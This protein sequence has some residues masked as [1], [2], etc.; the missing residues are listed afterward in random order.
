M[1]L[2]ENSTVLISIPALWML[3]VMT[4]VVGL[5]VVA[6]Y[7]SIDCDPVANSDIIN[8]NQVSRIVMQVT[9]MIV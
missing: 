2:V 7:A 4:S 1:L 8:A 3:Y 9:Y 6:Y 5:T